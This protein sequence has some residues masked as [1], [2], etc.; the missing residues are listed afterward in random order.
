M[1]TI[2]GGNMKAYIYTAVLSLLISGCGSEVIQVVEGPQGPQGEPGETVEVPTQPEFVGE[3]YMPYSGFAI[4]TTNHEN[5]YNTDVGLQLLNPNNTICTLDLDGALLD[6]H[7]E[8]LVYT[9][10]VTMAAGNCRS[11]SDV[12]LLTSGS[13]T[14]QYEITIGFNS[15]DLLQIDLL[16][17][18]TSSGVRTLVIDRSLVEE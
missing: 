13:V 6:A 17:F 12:A 3:Y 14:Y 10:S 2:L 4:I 8:Q 16:I 1:V 9:G 7:N 11:D 5:K 18:Q 15:D